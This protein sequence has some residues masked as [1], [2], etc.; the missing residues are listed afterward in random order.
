[1]KSG[2]AWRLGMKDFHVLP[3]P[4]RQGQ[5][6]KPT[7]IIVLVSLVCLF[8]VCAYVYPPH[9]SGA[10]YMFTSHGCKAVIQNWLPPPERAL[11]DEE[12]ASR[13][14][15]RD[16]LNMPPTKAATPKVAF[17]FLT[18]GALPFE[19]LWDKFFQVRYV[20][21]E[22]DAV[23]ILTPRINCTPKIYELILFVN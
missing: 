9:S 23:F 14:V 17:L 11:T 13:V 7:W 12:V 19:K 15:V 3:G 20:P 4:R 18:P 22:Y 8:L 21:S 1:M 16:I 6:K 5:N 2:Q 10:C